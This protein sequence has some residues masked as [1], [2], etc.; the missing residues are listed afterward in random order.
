VSTEQLAGEMEVELHDKPGA[1]GFYGLTEEQA[2][3]K[4]VKFGKNA[5]TEKA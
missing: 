4:L 1:P 2:K 5:L 3:K